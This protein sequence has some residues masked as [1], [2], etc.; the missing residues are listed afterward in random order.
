M[1]D[2][3]AQ[4]ASEILKLYFLGGSAAIKWTQAQAWTLVKLLSVHPQLGYNAVLLD[5]LFAQDETPLHELAQ[6]ELITISSTLEGRPAA[7]KPGRPVFSAAFAQLADDKVFSAQMELRRLTFLSGEEKTI[8]EK[9][10]E[11]LTRFKALPPAHAKEI[12]TRIRYLLKKIQTSQRKIESYEVEIG[13][14]KDIL[15]SEA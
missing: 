11:E 13:N 14:V 4:A 2:I 15:K 6:S 10:E 12:E 1:K 3:I 7:I 5:P 9:A 8:I